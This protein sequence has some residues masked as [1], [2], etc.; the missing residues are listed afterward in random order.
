MSYNI[1]IVTQSKEQFFHTALLGQ[2]DN[3]LLNGFMST[4]LRQDAADNET[5]KL[6][7][8]MELAENAGGNEIAVYNFIAKLMEKL[9]YDH[10]NRIIFLRRKICFYVGTSTAP[11]QAG[12]CIMDGND[13]IIL[14]VH[15]DELKDPEP[16]VIA[17]AIAAAYG[18]WSLHYRRLSTITFPAITMHSTYPIFYKITVTAQLSDAVRNGLYPPTETRVLR[19]VPDLP[20]PTIRGCTFSRTESRSWLAWRHSNNS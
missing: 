8:Y 12:V 10:G 1:S 2:T 5:A 14:L 6:L 18:Y 19:Y 13:K 7:Q 11:A 16:Q 15:A 4:L 17:E 20:L 9:E 3:P